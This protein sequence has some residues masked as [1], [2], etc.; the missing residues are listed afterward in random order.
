MLQEADM[1]ITSITEVS[2]SLDAVELEE[3]VL[4]A[5]TPL[6]ATLDRSGPRY[7]VGFHPL[8]WLVGH[9]NHNLVRTWRNWD[10]I[11]AA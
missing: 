11:R 6:A 3:V 9:R 10:V 2:T 4:K 7:A 1:F 8:P 5:F